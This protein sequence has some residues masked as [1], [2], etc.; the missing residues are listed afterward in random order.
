MMHITSKIY[1]ATD[2]S[3]WR[4]L[5]P[6][7]RSVFGSLEYAR[8]TEEQT[9]YPAQLLV[10][11]AGETQVAVPFFLR[12]VAR[13]EFASPRDQRSDAVTPEFTGPMIVCGDPSS[14]HDQFHAAMSAV[15]RERGIIAEFMHLN[16]WSEGNGLLD[17][18][19]VSYN[20]DIVWVDLRVDL[21]TLWARHFEHACRKNIMRSE[22]E[23]IRIFEAESVDHIVEFHR[24]YIATMV[25][26]NASSQYYFPLAYFLRLFNEMRGQARF[27]MAAC[28]SQIIGGILYMHDDDTVYSF[29]GGAD[30]TFQQMRP[31]NAI[32]YDT[33]RW[34]AAHGKKRLVLGGGHRPEDGIFRFKSSFSKYVAR[35]STYREVHLL[36]DY[37]RLEAQWCEHYHRATVETDYFPSYRWIPANASSSDSRPEDR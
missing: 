16:P 14:V 5:V 8:I 19:L 3:E 2:V 18:S 1:S 27:T 17:P 37:R 33:I 31:S 6:A 7:T 21:E 13:L 29:L 26:T 10:V 36:N 35:F 22:R 15:F 34:G 24:I 4:S 9:A 20:R 28:G 23:G 11:E 32:V 30:P 25:R 12:P